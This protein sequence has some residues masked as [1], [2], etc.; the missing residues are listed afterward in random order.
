MPKANVAAPFNFRE[1]GK[2]SAYKKGEQDLTDAAN[3]HAEA[4]GFLV[5]PKAESKEPAG[6]K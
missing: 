3:A 5:K 1:G 4:N 6:D 2:V